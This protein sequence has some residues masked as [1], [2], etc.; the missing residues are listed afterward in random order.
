MYKEDLALNNQQW[1]ICH[2]TKPIFFIPMIISIKDLHHHHFALISL[3]SYL[4]LPLSLSSLLSLS[5]SL[6]LS[7]H[8]SLSFITPGR[9]SRHLEFAHR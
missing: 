9:F 2:K 8:L 1:L 4:F 5:L 3:I 7:F 6:S